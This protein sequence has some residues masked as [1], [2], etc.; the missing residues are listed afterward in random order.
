VIIW[1]TLPLEGVRGVI[2]GSIWIITS[3]TIMIGC[4]WK[5]TT[6]KEEFRSKFIG[7]SILTILGPWVLLAVG[8]AIAIDRIEDKIKKAQTS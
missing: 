2:F 1:L 8:I 5:D 7:V 6:P 3:L 4:L